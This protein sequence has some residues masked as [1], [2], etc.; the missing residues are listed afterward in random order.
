MKLENMLIQSV[1]VIDYHIETFERVVMKY[2]TKH[3]DICLEKG[4]GVT[5]KDHYS[6]DWQFY[7]WS[8]IVVIDGIEGEKE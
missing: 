6:E 1:T 2:K 3:N 5:I 7:P 8:S 4:L